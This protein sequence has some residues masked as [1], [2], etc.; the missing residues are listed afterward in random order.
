MEAGRPYTVDEASQIVRDR[1]KN[2]GSAPI[3]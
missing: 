1:M 3:S 2:E